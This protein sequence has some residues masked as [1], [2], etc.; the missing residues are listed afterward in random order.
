M[1]IQ[2]EWPASR[3]AMS[4]S[5]NLTA[6]NAV[7]FD[8]VNGNFNDHN[9]HLGHDAV[10]FYW[11]MARPVMLSLCAS[12]VCYLDGIE[13]SYGSVHPLREASKIQVGHFKL[14]IVGEGNDEIDDQSFFRLIYPNGVWQTSDKLPEVENILP[15]GGSYVNDLRYFNDVILAQNKGDDIL[16]MLELEYKRFLI[17]Q[18]QDSGC[19]DGTSHQT[20]HIFKKDYRFERIREQLKDKTLTECVVDRTFLMEKVWPE[21]EQGEQWDE[22]FGEEEKSDLLRSLS[23]EHIVAKSRYQVPELVFQDFYK[24]GLDTYY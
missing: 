16:K 7:T 23:P 5:R 17:W 14:V 13:V 19:F 2:F 20:S 24:V 3:E 9:S 10:I 15:N 12:H 11:R 18:E 4:I 21:L 1:N 8:A 6:D 22:L